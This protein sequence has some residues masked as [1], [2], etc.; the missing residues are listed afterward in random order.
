MKISE[1]I[2]L[3][4]R[5]SGLS[6]EQLAE[7]LGVSRQAVSK[8]ES[9]QALPETEKLL[10]LA[11]QF[12]VTVDSLLRE[13]LQPQSAGGSVEHSRPDAPCCA[14]ASQLAK[15]RGKPAPGALLLGFGALLLALWLLGLATGAGQAAEQSSAV[16][17]NGSALL[18]LSA[19]GVLAAGAACLIASAPHRKGGKKS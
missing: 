18:L 3:L 8:W 15:R 14:P 6:Q 7:R 5:C 19:L 13:D 16:T 9:E 10:P 1:K 2:F 11:E 17:L 12:G 4:R